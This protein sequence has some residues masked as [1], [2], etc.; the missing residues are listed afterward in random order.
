[1]QI[2]D[3]L[4]RILGE[5]IE[6]SFHLGSTGKVKADPGH[7][8]QVIMN[9]V[10]NARDAMPGGGKLVVETANA[11]LDE[12]YARD[13]LGVVPGPHVMLAI[14]DTGMGMDRDIQQRIFEPFF[15]TKETG[16]GT[17]LGL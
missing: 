10:V 15:T 16:K 13:H 9:L 12:H 11:V 6:L 17:G 14:S 5:D 3:M 8:E 2:S 7:I 4:K 1:R